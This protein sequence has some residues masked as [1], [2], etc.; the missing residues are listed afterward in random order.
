MSGGQTGVDRGALDAGLARGVRCG[1]W[2]PAERR[3]EDGTI[4]SRYPVTPLPGADYDARTR[5]NVLDSDGTVVITFGAP[6]GGTRFTI[7]C[8]REH[9]KSHLVLDA[10]SE[11]GED[12][13]ARIAE[14]AATLPRGLLN[15][16]GPRASDAPAAHEYAR[17]A[18]ARAIDVLCA[19]S[20]PDLPAGPRPWLDSQS[21]GDLA[22][23]GVVSMSRGVCH[24]CGAPLDA[25]GYA[26][27]AADYCS[28][29]TEADG[30]L[31]TKKA[32]RAGIARWM[33]SWQ[34]GLGDKE[35][36]RRARRYM[37][38]MPAWAD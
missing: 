21:G 1:G 5:R 38:S 28:Y 16:A 37:R 3:A 2:C 13:A 20:T 12:A 7:E 32:V 8:C 23:P 31:K 33:Q 22:K 24:S 19:A 34:P 6:A 14:F 17:A 15:V 27:S 29:C 26:G 10:A 4:P 11:P 30:T 25:P 9:G 35:A 36:L 18:I